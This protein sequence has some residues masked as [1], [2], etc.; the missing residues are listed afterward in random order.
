M[1]LISATFQSELV[2]IFDVGP[3]GNPSGK[4]VGLDISKAYMNYISAGMNTGG[5]PFAAMPGTPALGSALGDIIV[6]AG[7]TATDGI[8]I[9]AG[10]PGGAPISITTMGEAEFTGAKGVTIGSDA[11]PTVDIKGT[12][13]N[14][15]GSSEPAILGKKFSDLFK[16]HTHPTPNG[17]SGPL[18]P[19]FAPKLLKTM[20]KK[21]F[22]GK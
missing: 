7:L 17:P 13:I 22:L 2:G 5:F 19:Q 16:D 3:D 6:Q 21:V 10:F 15:G 1:P 4:L 8:T 20:S 11:T 9:S 12:A 14:V 18:S